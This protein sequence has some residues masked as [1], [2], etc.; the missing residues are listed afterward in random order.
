[1]ISIDLKFGADNDRPNLSRFFLEVRSAGMLFLEAKFVVVAE[2][3][4]G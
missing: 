3:K 4:G 2:K 1:M